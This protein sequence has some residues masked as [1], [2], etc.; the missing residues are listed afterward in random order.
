[1]KRGASGAQVIALQQVLEHQGYLQPASKKA[2]GSWD[3][4]CGPELINAAYQYTLE[5][6]FTYHDDAV[7]TEIP[8][9]CVQTALGIQPVYGR[10]VDVAR[11]QPKVDY[12][13]LK[14]GGVSFAF[15]KATDFQHEKDRGFVDSM[16]HEHWQGASNAQMPKGAYMFWH[17][18]LDP[19][20]Q[21]DFFI[22]QVQPMYRA[23]DLRPVIDVE[24]NDKISSYEVNRRL[25]VVIDRLIAH[26]GVPPII[27]SSCR[28]CVEQGITVGAECPWWLAYYVGVVDV[29]PGPKKDMQPTYKSGPPLPA[30]CKEWAIWQSGYGP[31]LP[32]CE[33]TEIDRDLMRNVSTLL[34]ALTL[35]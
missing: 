19:E 4:I 17:P 35:K 6:N 3:G 31:R 22:R 1:M 23:G 9:G 12:A 29:D 15:I 25:Q 30:Q 20:A 33:S 26:F 7:W 14:R 32:G 5:R 27:Y 34:P 28:V 11:Y 10:G 18:A 8:D 24:R 13:K 16:F 2:D 21:A